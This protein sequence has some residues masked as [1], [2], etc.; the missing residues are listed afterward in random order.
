ML[1]LMFSLVLTLAITPLTA[2]DVELQN[3]IC[4]S[5]RQHMDPALAACGSFAC[6]EALLSSREETF[7][8][9][10][11]VESG[12]SVEKSTE[13]M[14]AYRGLKDEHK[15]LIE[16]SQVQC[17][18][19]TRL[20][21]DTFDKTRY[22]LEKSGI[23][24]RKIKIT[25]RRASSGDRSLGKATHANKEAPAVID[26]PPKYKDIPSLH[27]IAHEV[28]HLD[29]AHSL[30]QLLMRKFLRASSADIF[31]ATKVDA[32]YYFVLLQRMHEMQADLLPLMRFKDAQIAQ[33]LLEE[34]MPE[35]NY[36]YA[37]VGLKAMWNSSVSLYS[38]HSGCTEELPY[39]LKINELKKRGATHMY[40]KNDADIRIQHE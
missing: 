14:G 9:L 33:K 24:P 16:N 3:I 26:Y 2:S 37:R 10:T 7:A 17:Y 23:N 29:E 19:T 6:I 30:K 20:E 18:E 38:I 21:K 15:R 39:I 22:Y 35:C 28:T 8:L 1:I 25:S 36:L 13:I 5:A 34:K 32:N 11:L 4:E 40:E 27:T 12:I 31:A